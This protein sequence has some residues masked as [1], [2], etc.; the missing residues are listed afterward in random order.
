MYD[1]DVDCPITEAEIASA[2][3]WFLDMS[4]SDQKFLQKC[5]K[6]SLA[7][8]CAIAYIEIVLLSL[9]SLTNM[10]DVVKS[11]EAAA[12]AVSY[13]PESDQYWKTF[14]T[15]STAQ[16]AFGDLNEIYDTVESERKFYSLGKITAGYRQIF[17][18][19]VEYIG[20]LKL[21]V[22]VM[23]T[24]DFNYV[25]NIQKIVGNIE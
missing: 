2:E 14:N 19:L 8:V 16:E 3:K 5:S 24:L 1:P 25:K 10:R 4:L 11:V 6:Q 21:S 9:S 13:P 23:N 17:Y 12:E 22:S 15:P 7:I 18:S 20:S